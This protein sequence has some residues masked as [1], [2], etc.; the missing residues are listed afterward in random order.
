MEQLA[1]NIKHIELDKLR[2]SN[3]CLT[4]NAWNNIFDCSI[5]SDREI[6]YFTRND[7]ETI[8]I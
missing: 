8:I 3:E 4:N 5:L 1:S 2:S 6:N 7:L